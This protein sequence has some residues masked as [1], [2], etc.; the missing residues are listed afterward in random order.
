MDTQ[1]NVEIVSAKQ[2]EG[3][4]HNNSDNVADVV[5]GQLK[6]R[7][8]RPSPPH[9]VIPSL[10]KG[11]QVNDPVGYVNTAPNSGK[12]KHPS[13]NFDREPEHGDAIPERT[14]ATQIP[15]LSHNSGTGLV[16]EGSMIREQI[17]EGLVDMNKAR[18]Q[19]VGPV[20]TVPN[21]FQPCVSYEMLD[22]GVSM[23]E[24]VIEGMKEIDKVM[25]RM[26]NKPLRRDWRDSESGR[27]KD[28]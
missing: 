16:N 14:L 3:E 10:S 20:T 27:L 9:S 8:G 4:E 7:I 11:Q 28:I 19:I 26:A 6:T 13:V 22:S 23:P 5:V 24:S 17:A 15:I 1:D 25:K 12:G 18:N 2:F 21:S